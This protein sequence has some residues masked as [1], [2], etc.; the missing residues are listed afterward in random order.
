MK[1]FAFLSGL[2]VALVM[3]HMV[4][5]VAYNH[6]LSREKFLS[7]IKSMGVTM[8]HKCRVTI[9]ENVAP[10]RFFYMLRL[11]KLSL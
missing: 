3:P 10:P 5:A 2:L 6:A 7:V 4:R 9:I 11:M 1:K 8:V